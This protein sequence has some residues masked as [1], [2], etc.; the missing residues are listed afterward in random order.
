M[1]V[2]DENASAERT[3]KSWQAARLRISRGDAHGTGR[4]HVGAKEPL[5][6]GGFE[7]LFVH[8]TGFDGINRLV[9]KCLINSE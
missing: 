3:R 7:V 1:K 4:V 9:N 2:D 5:K 6:V 8:D